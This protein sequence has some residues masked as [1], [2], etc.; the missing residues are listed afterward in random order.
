MK[1]ISISL[2]SSAGDMAFR[3]KVA[4]F[5]RPN[6][7]DRPLALSFKNLAVSQSHTT[8]RKDDSVSLLT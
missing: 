8:Q 4:V 6:D 5:D 1:P 3:M 2:S 7:F